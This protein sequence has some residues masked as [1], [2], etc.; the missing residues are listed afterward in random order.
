MGKHQIDCWILLHTHC[1]RGRQTA[2]AAMKASTCAKQTARLER[3]LADADADNLRLASDVRASLSAVAGVSAASIAA[4]EACCLQEMARTAAQESWLRRA[5]EVEVARER[6]LRQAAEAEVAALREQLAGRDQKSDALRATLHEARNAAESAAASAYK[7]ATR[8]T[9]AEQRLR[10]QE[11]VAAEAAHIA[12][13]S[14]AASEALLRRMDGEMDVSFPHHTEVYV[15]L[16]IQ[17]IARLSFVWIRL[18]PK[19]AGVD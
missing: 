2:E 15:H 10:Q 6:G 17:L 1:M 19:R 11:A 16:P 13:E 14:Q 4:A 9:V 3:T 12:A 5:A 7:V 18:L 8:A